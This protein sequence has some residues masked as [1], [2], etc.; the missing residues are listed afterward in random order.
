MVQ[1]TGLH[2]ISRK[3]VAVAFHR[4]VQ[5][6]F[7][8]RLAIDGK[9]VKEVKEF[10]LLLALLDKNFTFNNHITDLKGK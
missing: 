6:H 9:I 5:H 1:N 3:S 10:K 4:A 2:P 8:Y 7:N